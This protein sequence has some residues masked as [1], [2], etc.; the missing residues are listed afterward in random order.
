MKL[1]K[2]SK[3]GLPSS[4]FVKSVNLAVQ[5]IITI[6]GFVILFYCICEVISL[7][8]YKNKLLN[9]LVSI[10]IEVTSGCVKI[11]EILGKNSLYL[12]FCLSF[13]PISTL[14]QVYYFTD[15]FDI[16][17]TLLFSRLI[18]TPV[19]LLVFS[20][21]IQLFPVAASVANNNSIVIQSFQNTMEISATLFMITI[22]FLCIFDRNKLFT[23]Q[24]L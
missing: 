19:S 13:L 14:C 3:G 1:E 6:C 12:C 8:I 4:S 18:H 11:I 24:D 16:I 20:V 23:N 9:I 17:K 7:Y 5:N 22:V 15:D 10:C 21:L 2:V